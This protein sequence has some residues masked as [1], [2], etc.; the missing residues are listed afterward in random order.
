MYVYIYIYIHNLSLSLYIY[1]YICIYIYIY[2]SPRG[3]MLS[4][5]KS[6]MGNVIEWEMLSKGNGKCYLREI[7][8]KGNGQCYRMGNVI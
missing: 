4:K 2:R 6:E 8:S 1:I 7:L 3:E 5:R